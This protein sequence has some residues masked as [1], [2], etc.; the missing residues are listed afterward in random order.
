MRGRIA[1]SR[2]YGLLLVSF[3]ARGL[4]V[5][6]VGSDFAGACKAEIVKESPKAQ[7]TE[8]YMREHQ[9]L[10][11]ATCREIIRDEIR[12][13]GSI[14]VAEMYAELRKVFPRTN[15]AIFCSSLVTKD[16]G[17]YVTDGVIDYTAQPVRPTRR[18]ARR[19]DE[20]KKAKVK[21]A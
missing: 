14:S 4:G 3:G 21:A 17:F 5:G 1:R 15:F 8:S 16:A 9:A 6:A 18:D 20:R 12:A 2:V 13:R 19:W 10:S 7:K 11:A